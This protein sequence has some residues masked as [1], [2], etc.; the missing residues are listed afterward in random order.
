MLKAVAECG[1]PVLLA[2]SFGGGVWRSCIL[3]CWL[4]RLVVVC[5]LLS[6]CKEDADD[7]VEEVGEGD[8]DRR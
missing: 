3:C 1:D 5:G 7:I 6:R 8:V 4:G 2:W